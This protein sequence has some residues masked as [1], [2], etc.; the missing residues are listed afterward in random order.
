MD[1]YLVL[2]WTLKLLKYIEEKLPD[3]SHIGIKLL[4]A[5]SVLL[6]ITLG[7][8]IPG[9]WEADA[10]PLA[11]IGL[12]AGSISATIGAYILFRRLIWV[13]QD[14]RAPRITSLRWK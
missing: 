9:E 5:G 2:E 11:F 4:L 7:L 14:K 1:G 3:D 10:A 12:L 6:A 13:W 8:H